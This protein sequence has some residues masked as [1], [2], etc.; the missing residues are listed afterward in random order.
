MSRFARIVRFFTRAQAA[1]VMV[2]APQTS[3]SLVS[4]KVELARSELKKK[5]AKYAEGSW[6]ETQHMKLD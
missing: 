2:R 5:R 6:G 3:Q 4:S 1:P